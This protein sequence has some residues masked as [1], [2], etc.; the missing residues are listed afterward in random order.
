M[1]YLFAAVAATSLLTAP[2]FAQEASAGAL[3]Q[4]RADGEE[5]NTGTNLKLLSTTV[6]IQ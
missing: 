3:A 5:V 4:K 2:A 1:R 6:G